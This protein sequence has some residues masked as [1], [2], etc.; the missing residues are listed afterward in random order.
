MQATGNEVVEIEPRIATRAELERVHS[1]QYLDEVLNEHR[2]S[3]W[4]GPRP[5]LA[6]LAAT[7]AG[8]TLTALDLLLRGITKT[9][10]HFPGAKHHAQ[11]DHSSG[12]CIFADFALAAEIATRDCG[13]KVAILDIDAHHGDGTE[14]LTAD[15]PN[16]MTFS[17]HE[18]GIFPGTGNEDQE[19]KKVFNFPLPATGLDGELGKGDIALT[20]GVNLFLQRAQDFN[21]DLIFIAC[22]ADGHQE[23]PLSSLQYSVAGYASVAEQVRKVYP[24]MPILMGGAG[25]Y[26]PDSRTPE[27][28]SSFARHLSQ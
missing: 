13:K 8:G 14:N 9:A 18:R 21:P 3:Q 11:Y 16:V 15:N 26:L 12:F 23:D 22:G 24:D 19:D 10:I 4:S 27:V 17:I 7:F 2:T 20:C 5:D 28:W 1:S 25:G 6:E